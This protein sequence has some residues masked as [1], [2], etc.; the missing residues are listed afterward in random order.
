MSAK[1][2]L[3]VCFR[4]HLR[5][6]KRAKLN[7]QKHQTQGIL[8][9][10]K[11]EGVLSS[12][13]P[14]AR[15]GI[16]ADEMG[17]GKTILMLS[18]VVNNCTQGIKKTLV[19]VPPALLKQWE[20]VFKRFCNMNVLVYHG[21]KVKKYDRDV[22]DAATVVLTTYG[23]VS[24]RPHED[25]ERPQWV[26]PLWNVEWERIIYDEAHHLR[27]SSS[28]Q[29]KGALCL[30]DNK[31]IQWF[32]TGTPINN[33]L[34]DLYALMHL[35]GISIKDYLNPLKLEKILETYMLRRT[36]KS[37]GI[38][39]PKC[40]EEKIPVHYE[41]VNE[42]ELSRSVHA[43]LSLSNVSAKNVNTCVRYLAD[44]PLPLLLRAKQCCIL[45]NLVK[46]VLET[47]V[48]I[49][50]EMGRI[51]KVDTSAKLKS[52]ISKIEE[53]KD[54]GKAK[55]VFCHFRKE[56]DDLEKALEKDFT[57]EK[58][59]GRTSKR[60]RNNILT[61]RD[62]DVL[63]IQIKTGCEGLNLQQYSEIYFT[64]PHWNPA[65]EDQAVCRAHRMGQKD[66]V[67]VYKF[68]TKFAEKFAVTLDE[69][70]AG[71]QDNKR[72]LQQQYIKLTK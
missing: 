37:V 63:L 21:H 60:D 61:N 32:V 4:R 65:V 29:H 67:H 27:N 34:N 52:V 9:A 24:I 41:D 48:P 59:D 23:M 66:D 12:Y 55:L 69:Y 20:D 6:L 71:I 30:G 18:C 2:D 47:R 3:K 43:M 57:V 8:W 14:C 45:P 49:G 62:P 44:C 7:V 35:S 22:L 68:I 53:N 11:Q 26:S 39:L 51:S 56:I 5:W 58:I 33:N 40:I 31:P 64:S 70:C 10:L 50:V 19:V 72:D 38:V 1:S 28:N 46:N 54:S 16:L 17:L 36:K 42:E 15:G 25:R 13:K